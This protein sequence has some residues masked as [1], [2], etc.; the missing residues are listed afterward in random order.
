[1][2]AVSEA[3]FAVGSAEALAAYPVRSHLDDGRVVAWR[4]AGV[5]G[6]VAID[7]ERIRPVPRALAA[8]LGEDAWG[9]WTRLEVVAKLTDTPVVLL[10]PAP[11]AAERRPDD[12]R[13]RTLTVTEPGGGA[14]VVSVGVRDR[15]RV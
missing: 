14:V 6:Q 12:I 4:G 10:L 9:R 3:A 5:R 1:M 15:H 13:L 8:R 7:A 11:G 2:A